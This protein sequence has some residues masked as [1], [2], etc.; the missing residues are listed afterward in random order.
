MSL[1]GVQN[2]ILAAA[3]AVVPASVTHV[4]GVVHADIPPG[5]PFLYTIDWSIGQQVDA[6]NIRT[7]KTYTGTLV[8][9][10]IAT[11]SDMV[12]YGEAILA[13]VEADSTLLGLVDDV[14][15]GLTTDSRANVEDVEQ[16]VVALPIEATVQATGSSVLIN[17]VVTVQ[18]S[19]R[20]SAT[21][22]T[23]Y[24]SAMETALDATL[25]GTRLSNDIGDPLDSITKGTTRY[26]LKFAASALH[27]D[28]P[29]NADFRQVAMQLSVWRH[30]AA[31]STERD[32]T[33]GTYLT[34]TVAILDPAYWK[35]SL[36]TVDILEDP[37]LALSDLTRV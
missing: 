5:A 11:Y 36:S 23:T 25:S 27:T 12:A 21:V 17:W 1:M 3:T 15:V 7:G 19:L 16:R 8:L 2:A 26:Q 4:G 22:L 29:S 28:Q 13:A 18:V 24:L 9:V 31:G 34:E 32:Y 6:A 30:Q 35:A 20:D 14:L 37:E 33:E 10:H